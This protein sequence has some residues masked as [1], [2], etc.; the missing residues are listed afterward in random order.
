MSGPTV[1]AKNVALVIEVALV[2]QADTKLYQTNP[3]L[4]TGD[5]K[6][7]TDD[8]TLANITTLPTGAASSKRVKVSLSAAEMNGDNIWIQFSDAAG[9]EWCDFAVCIQTSAR[10]VDDLAFPTTTGRSLDVTA[11]GAAGIDLAN[12]EGQGTTLALS[13]TT[14]A[15]VTT[16][17]NVTTVNGL[18]AGV[19]TAAAVAT[20]AIDADALAADAV[21]EIQAGLAT[22]AALTTV[23]ADTDDIQ[24][25]LPAALVAGRI[26]ASVGAM[27]ASVVTA[28]SIATAAL[29][30]AK[31]AAGAID[32]AAVATDAAN[33]IADALLD[34]ASAV[35]SYTVRQI[36]RGMAAVLMG[37]VTGAQGA[38]V[39][40]AAD[41]SA[42]RVTATT[43]SGNRSAIT[44]NLGS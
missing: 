7:Q 44:L 1:P 14:I 32:A 2:S 30:A 8:G 28:A 18:A 9:A 37:K 29:T 21:T 15:T 5:V 33:E 36:L 26:D 17:A 38:E 12:V 23:Q 31:F 42:N 13:A 39:Y 3:T 22:A 43:S 20:G 10:G 27:A 41:D 4:A 40:R 19:V 35:D 34:R 11:T 24:T 25:R 6:V 16:A